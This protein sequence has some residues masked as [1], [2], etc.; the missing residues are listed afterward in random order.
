ML[1]CFKIKSVRKKISIMPEDDLAAPWTPEA[2]TT[3][4][5]QFQ[6]VSYKVRKAQSNVL[7]FFFILNCLFP[8]NLNP[9]L[10][11]H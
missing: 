6:G 10:D 7:I 5:V 9:V 1:T 2:K 3:R 11:F 4:P 8:M